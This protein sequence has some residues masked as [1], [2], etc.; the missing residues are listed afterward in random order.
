MS[1]YIEDHTEYSTPTRAYLLNALYWNP[2]HSPPGSP[3]L[4]SDEYEVRFS[5]LVK[6]GDPPTLSGLYK[7]ILTPVEY[8]YYLLAGVFRIYQLGINYR[9]TLVDP[10]SLSES[11][12]RLFKLSGGGWGPETAIPIAVSDLNNSYVSD[13]E[14]ISEEECFRLLTDVTKIL[15]VESF[16]PNF[17]GIPSF[18]VGVAEGSGGMIE[19]KNTFFGTDPENDIYVIDPPKNVKVYR[20]GALESENGEMFTDIPIPPLAS[21]PIQE[22]HDRLEGM[23]SKLDEILS[24]LTS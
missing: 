19:T 13:L 12:I 3:W 17:Y 9:I 23:D 7:A 22:L 2:L 14:S 1:I 18:K 5:Q 4:P 24:K 8:V 10:G 15:K 20:D 6:H 16:G 11:D 21:K